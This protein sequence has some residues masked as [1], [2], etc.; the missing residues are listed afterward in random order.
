MII[1]LESGGTKLVTAVAE[2]GGELRTVA[3]RYRRPDQDALNT[4][5]DL[6]EMGRELVGSEPVEA[7]SYGFGG[8]VRRADQHPGPCFHESGWEN[9]DAPRYLQ[10]AFQ[11]PV[12]I[13]NDCN[14]AALGE[15]HFGAGETRGTLFY[16][17]IG[18]GIGGGIV[19]RGRLLQ[20][21][22]LG[23]AEIG[24]I[25]VDETGPECPCGNRGCLESLCS[26]P[27]LSRL[28][29]RML[30]TTLDTRTLMERFRKRDPAASRVV[31]QAAGYLGKVFGLTINLLAPQT[32]VIGGGVMTDNQAF[33]ELIAARTEAYVF[34]FFRHRTRFFLSALGE[35][36]VCRGAAVYA[37]Q[38]LAEQKESQTT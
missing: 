36:V 1:C 11:A 33:L 7:V 26:G 30:G 3:R 32:I 23:E 35:N 17:T 31:D 19:H 20:S 25:V 6:V 13:E 24:H 37:I 21:G 4:L 38:R 12:F 15:A 28:A 34:P 8:T 5:T 9:I 27:A 14:L 10:E 18:T 29:S 16:A 2:S 22:A